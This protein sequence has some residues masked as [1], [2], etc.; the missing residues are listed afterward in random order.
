MTRL[1]NDWLRDEEGASAVEFAL[2]LTPLILLLFGVVHLCLLAYT[3]M[4]LNYATEATARCIVT[5]NAS[6]YAS[7]PCSTSSL[8]TSYFG[9]LYHGVSASPTLTFCGGTFS[10]CSGSSY[11]C[12]GSSS[13]FQVVATANYNINAGIAS[14][15]VGLTSK[16]CFPH[17]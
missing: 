5:S 6:G 14:K 4:Q 10:S 1:L 16:A 17:S 9:G 12:T 11:T 3:A 2:L 15:A 7:S 13:N 8:A